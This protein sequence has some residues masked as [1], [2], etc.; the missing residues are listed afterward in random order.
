M[1]VELASHWIEFAGRPARMVVVLDVTERHRLEE[2]FRQAQRMEAIGQLAGG[3]AHDFNNILG[4][5]VGYGEIVLR[6]L[7]PA[8]ALK[9]KV[10][11]ILKAAE[12]A[13]ALTRQLLAFSRKQVLQPR[14]LDLNDVVAGMDM[15]FQRLI[16][17]NIELTMAFGERVASV[18][19]DPGQ[20][21]QVLM[22]LVVNA[23][24]AIA[25]AGSIV[26]ETREV[27][28]DAAYVSLHPSAHPGPHV[29]MSIRDT[30]EGMDAATLARIF[31]PFFTTK[32]VGK[33]TGLGLSTVY[34]IVD[35]S[36]GHVQVTSAPGR[37]S[38]FE[39]YLPRL[40]DAVTAPR[41]LETPPPSSRAETILLVE[42][43]GALRGLVNETLSL[44][45][46]RVLAA[47]TPAEAL[48]IA[49]AHPGPIDAV[50]TD[51]VMPGMSGRDLAERLKA[52]RPLAPIV[53]M[54]GYTDDAIGVGGLLDP[55]T[56]FLQKPFTSTALLWKIR[57]A[58]DGVEAPVAS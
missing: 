8:D 43:E 2:H 6:R 15:L 18:R 1:D 57:E 32:P 45:G 23:R 3:I 21:E 37:G 28:L 24:D 11:E 40:E 26:I 10:A 14:V 4:V 41:A 5:I 38:T 56:L 53:Y 27:D 29:V 7:P 35:Q 12:R 51:V 49:L 39:V 58:V 46:Y 13:S 22:N 55:G 47:A 19:A 42:D 50:L 25:G 20:V 44:D 31:E 17:E 30:G 34:G 33:G 9:G 36:G 54:S 52:L 16:G 48:D